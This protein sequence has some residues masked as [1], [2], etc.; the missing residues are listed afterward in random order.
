MKKVSITFNLTVDNSM[1]HRDIR[2]R[3][4][5]LFIKL[6]KVTSLEVNNVEMKKK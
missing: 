2:E 5:F 6:G 4:K 1:T 3:F